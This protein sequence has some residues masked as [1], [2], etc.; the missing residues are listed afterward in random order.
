MAVV[1]FQAA[2]DDGLRHGLASGATELADFTQDDSIETISGRDG[3]GA[4]EA[5]VYGHGSFPRSAWERRY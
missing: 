4:V 1:A 2:F 5:S 3:Q